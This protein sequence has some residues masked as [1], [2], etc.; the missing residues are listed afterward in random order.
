LTLILS[1][2][3]DRGKQPEAGKMS[4][5]RESLQERSDERGSPS[6][7][8]EIH[9]GSETE[10]PP[11]APEEWPLDVPFMEGLTK[12]FMGPSD[13]ALEV[14]LIGSIPSSK[15]EEFYSNLP[16]WSKVE[17]EV[18]KPPPPAGFEPPIDIVFGLK[19]G[20]EF[21]T[22]SIQEYQGRTSVRLQY[23]RET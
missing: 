7:G 22:V 20:K 8:E 23:R 16:G 14:L 12:Q 15:V 6:S 9:E 11:P 2:C 17:I 21:L 18:P 19:K 3:V 1:A 4:P 10:P 5:G 13:G